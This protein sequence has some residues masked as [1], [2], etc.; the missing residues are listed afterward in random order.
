MDAFATIAEKMAESTRTQP[1][2]LEHNYRRSKVI[3][4]ATASEHPSVGLGCAR[5]EKPA[6]IPLWPPG[7]YEIQT[8]DEPRDQPLR[9]KTQ[10]NQRLYVP[11]G[12]PPFVT[13]S[14]SLARAAHRSRAPQNRQS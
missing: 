14:S 11:L 12:S 7:R 2:L 1:S 13:V 5:E 8:S 9:P 6:R 4:T 3:R 10:P